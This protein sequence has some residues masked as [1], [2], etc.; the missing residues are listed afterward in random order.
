[1]RIHKPEA[2][3]H[4]RHRVPNIPGSGSLEGVIGP[5]HA[6]FLATEHACVQDDARSHLRRGE[7]VFR[8]DGNK[9][10][11]ILDKQIHSAIKMQNSA[12]T[13]TWPMR[14]V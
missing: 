1:M 3:P 9:L 13:S 7:T 14:S 12:G 10:A 6:I 2:P 11:D 5:T 8:S 4:P